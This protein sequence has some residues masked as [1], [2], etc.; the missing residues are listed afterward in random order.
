MPKPKVDRRVKYTIMMLT[1]ALVELMQT[2]HI[3]E[4]S[5]TALCERADINRSTFYTHFKDV[6]DLLE[7]IEQ[8]ALSNIT[9]YLEK[10]DFSSKQPVSEQILNRILE[11]VQDNAALFQALLS[12]NCENGIQSEVIKLAQPF[13]MQL[14]QQT[15]E[16]TRKYVT[17][18]GTTGCISLIQK[19]LQ[20]GMPEPTEE[21]AGLMLRILYKGTSSFS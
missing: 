2:Q 6:Y 4:V 12:D 1:D 8:E 9:S 10:Q 5:V 18:F 15:N 20:D 11:Y 17:I 7:Y 13:D 21:I 14:G 3:S 19:W 16:R